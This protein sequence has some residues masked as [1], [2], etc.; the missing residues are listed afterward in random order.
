MNRRLLIIISLSA[1]LIAALGIAAWSLWSSRTSSG[2]IEQP[3]ITEQSPEASAP[4]PIQPAPAGEPA[5]DTNTL[6]LQQTAYA[7]AEGYGSYSTDAPFENLKALD[8]FYTE[9]LRRQ[10][11]RTMDSG[12]GEPA[13][14]Y[15]SSSRALVLEVIQQGEISAEV[16]VQVQRQ[17]RFAREEA[18][19]LS[20]QKLRLSMVLSGGQWLVDSAR[21]EQ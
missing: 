6:G 18:P 19:R 1:A 20:Y 9:G 16:W 7:F 3:P 11:E 4:D 14:F 15:S 12:A 10:V 8:R 17:E 5:V 13:A 2:R 21:W